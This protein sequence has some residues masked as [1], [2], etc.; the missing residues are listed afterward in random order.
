MAQEG[1]ER[2]RRSSWLLVKYVPACSSPFHSSLTQTSRRAAVTLGKWHN[3]DGWVEGWATARFPTV[4][5]SSPRRL[6]NGKRLPV[7]GG[8]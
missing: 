1:R 8:L 3:M 7:N 2:A 5:A 4:V 6:F